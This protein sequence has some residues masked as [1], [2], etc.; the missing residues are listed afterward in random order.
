MVDVT[1]LG[2]GGMLPMKNRWLTSCLISCQGH[3]I[4]I[5]CGEGTQIALKCAGKKCTPVDLI[6]ITH[7]HAD[8]ISGLPGFLLSMGNEGR[9]EPITIAG[10]KGISHIVR[11]LCVIAPN[12]PFEINYLEADKAQTFECG[13][14]TV[15][16]F[17]ACHGIRCYGYSV[18]LKRKGRFLPEKARENNVP[19]CIWSALQKNDTVEYEGS[20][21]T[22]DMV[23]GGER[24]GIKVTYC[25][26]SRPVSN[27]VS[28]AE[29]SD[30]LICEGLYYEPEKLDRAI[31]TG[32]MLYSEAATIAKNADVKQLWLT[33]FSPAVSDPQEGISAAK[34]IFP[35]TECGYDGKNIDI[36]F[37]EE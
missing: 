20:T 13:L 26:D 16:P 28:H 36:C 11:S 7:F 14:L 22:Y 6:C 25:T 10:P 5:D 12:L 34:D 27:I 35:P 3:S 4:L 32:H 33:H 24:K 2:C 18:E 29:N 8:H 23:S 9:T 21:F 19:M 31:C 15:T 37:D 30:L 1:L 17:E